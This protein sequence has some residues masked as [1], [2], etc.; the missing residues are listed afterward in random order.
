M[1]PLT[2][3]SCLIY[4]QLFVGGL[5]SYLPTVVCGSAHVLFTSSCLWEGSCL[6]YLQLFVGVFMRH[7]PSYKKLEVNKT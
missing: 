6:I 2:N 3:N 1:S 7:E 5:V 4:L